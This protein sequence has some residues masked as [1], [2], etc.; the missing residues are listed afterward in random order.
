MEPLLPFLL[1]MKDVDDAIAPNLN[2]DDISFCALCDFEVLLLWSYHKLLHK[3]L[4]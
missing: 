1:V 3:H 2:E 4:R